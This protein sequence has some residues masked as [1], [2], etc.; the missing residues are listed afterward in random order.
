LD[1]KTHD[2]SQQ[3]DA[4][5]PPPVTLSERTWEGVCCIRCPLSYT[6]LSVIGVALASIE[7]Y[8]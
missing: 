1:N 6:R 4:L 5:E 3:A 2:A 7:Q 8:E